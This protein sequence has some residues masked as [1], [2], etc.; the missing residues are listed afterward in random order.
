LRRSLSAALAL[1]IAACS[2]A[3]PTAGPGRPAGLS[4]AYLAIDAT[5]LYWLDPQMGVVRQPRSGGA[6]TVL[7]QPASAWQVIAVNGSDVFYWQETSAG[8]GAIMSVPKLGGDPREVAQGLMPYMI[9]VDAEHLYLSHAVEAEP[10]TPSTWTIVDHPLGGGQESMLDSSGGA[11]LGLAVA[12]PDLVG[13]SCEPSG[14]WALARTAGPRRPF[15]GDAFCPITL[16]VDDA[17]VCYADWD[18]GIYCVA[19]DG[20]AVRKVG[21]SY[22]GGLDAFVLDGAHVYTIG[23]PSLLRFTVETG[24]ELE[25]ADATGAVGIALADGVAYWTAPDAAG[26]ALSIHSVALPAP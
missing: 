1:S 3:D 7:A 22:A 20:G 13:T 15:V 14:V 24:D 11:A 26:G 6:P 17:N 10:P 18:K 9:A 19:R 4:S 8:A 25:V 21:P 5:A 12:G 16:A 23:S 2:S